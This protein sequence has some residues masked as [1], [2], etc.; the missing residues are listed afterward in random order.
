MNFVFFYLNF[1]NLIHLVNV[2]TLKFDTTIYGVQD[3]NVV[4]VVLSH[5]DYV[6]IPQYLL[7][8]GVSS[9]YIHSKLFK[10]DVITFR[11]P[12]LTQRRR[13]I[14]ILESAKYIGQNRVT[15]AVI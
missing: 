11:N 15:G 7:Y 2:L 4:F 5:L 10:I 13:M 9:V 1:F 14:D 12:N 6:A 3:V 8:P